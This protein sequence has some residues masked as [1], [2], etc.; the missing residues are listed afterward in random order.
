MASE[1]HKTVAYICDGKACKNPFG[2]FLGNPLNL[3]TCTHTTD[4]TH[5][6]YKPSKYPEL[7]FDR[8]E[9]D[10][11]YNTEGEV[12]KELYWEK[13]DYYS[14]RLNSEGKAAD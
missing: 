1:I 14:E 8:F 10:R 13:E 6:K 3:S 11:V 7:D 9:V 4:V 5:A 12:I 2:C